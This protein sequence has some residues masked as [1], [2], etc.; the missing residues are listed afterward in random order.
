MPYLD[1]SPAMPLICDF[2]RES[3]VRPTIQTTH[4]PVLTTPYAQVELPIPLTCLPFQ[5]SCGECSL[6]GQVYVYF[7]FPALCLVSRSLLSLHL[8][9]S[10]P[11]THPYY[12][13]AQERESWSPPPTTPLPLRSTMSSK[14]LTTRPMA[15]PKSTTGPTQAQQPSISAVWLTV[16]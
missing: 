16:H 9:I 13:Q 1:L 6:R 4:P 7:L 10:P 8:L 14:K 2:T 3:F 12:T 11:P 5:C 15:T